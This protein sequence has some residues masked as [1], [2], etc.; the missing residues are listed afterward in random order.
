MLISA[1]LNC[2]EPLL[3]LLFHLLGESAAEHSEM[4]FFAGFCI[5]QGNVSERLNNRWVGFF[6]SEKV[7]K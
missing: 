6:G 7:V 1:F 3:F 2:L 5:A 4:L